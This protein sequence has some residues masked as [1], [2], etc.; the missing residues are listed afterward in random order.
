MLPLAP[1][2][3]SQT[4]YIKTNC[5]TYTMKKLFF[6]L[7]LFTCSHVFAQFDAA[8]TKDYKVY[9][10]NLAIVGVRIYPEKV[11]VD[12]KYT[13][14]LPNDSINLSENTYLQLDGLDPQFYLLAL[15]KISSSRYTPVK[16]GSSIVFT[17]GFPYSVFYFI[18]QKLKMDGNKLDFSKHMLPLI[19]LI[20][21]P[22]DYIEKNPSYDKK[23]CFNVYNL[24]LKLAPQ[25]LEVLYLYGMLDALQVKGEFETSAAFKQRNL[26]DSLGKSIK[27][28]VDAMEYYI[29]EAQVQ[30]MRETTNEISYDADREIF[31][32]KWKDVSPVQIKVP[33]AEAPAFKANVLD[34]KLK[35]NGANL[36]RRTNGGYYVELVSFKDMDGKKTI[37]KNELKEDA[38]QLRQ[39]LVQAVTGELQKVYPK[40][41]I[42]N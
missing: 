26:P 30:V 28:S 2:V 39:A 25:Q 18:E 11:L 37:Y 31:T 23:S 32:L 19:H 33:L 17:A 1:G 7:V 13:S 34:K 24:D 16:Q 9:N 27:N 21:V 22:D 10:P 4:G 15:D 42:W 12:Y 29:E 5:Y 6:S 36:V 8:F 38:K 3:P 35:L 41:K 40:G 14:A 20:E